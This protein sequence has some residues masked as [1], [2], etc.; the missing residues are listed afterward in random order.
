VRPGT[1]RGYPAGDLLASIGRGK[2]FNDCP[3]ADE[4]LAEVVVKRV[5]EEQMWREHPEELKALAEQK[6]GELAKLSEL[7]QSER[8][9]RLVEGYSRSIARGQG[10]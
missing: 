7:P 6:R 1:C 8:M 9:K 5:L 4:L 2:Q 10:Q 3:I